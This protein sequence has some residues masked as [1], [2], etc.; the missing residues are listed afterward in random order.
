MAYKEDTGHKLE[1]RYKLNKNKMD[2]D[3]LTELEK[4]R[5]FR[6]LA[7]DIFP[8]DTWEY[9]ERELLDDLGLYSWFFGID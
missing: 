3:D 2:I 4:A 6:E 9:A 5:L 8:P 1:N 7:Q